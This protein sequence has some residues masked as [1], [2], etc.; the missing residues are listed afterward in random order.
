M[1]NLECTS[2]SLV[3]VT[4]KTA[5]RKRFSWGQVFGASPWSRRIA[6]PIPAGAAS[7][8]RHLRPEQIIADRVKLDAYLAGTG[9]V[10]PITA[11]WSKRTPLIED[12][13]S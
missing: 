13:G 7:R 11:A 2:R 12:V 1:S 4:R 8:H 9:N 3:G 5:Q 6:Q 10:I